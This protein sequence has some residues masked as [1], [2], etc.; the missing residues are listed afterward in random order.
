MTAQPP[1]GSLEWILRAAGHAQKVTPGPC[2]VVER[3]GRHAY[4]IDLSAG[5]SWPVCECGRKLPEEADEGR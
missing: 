1:F 5:D 2:A 4:V 3:T